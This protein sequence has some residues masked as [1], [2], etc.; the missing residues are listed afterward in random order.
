MRTIK[1]MRNR[2]ICELIDDLGKL[3]EAQ[4]TIYKMVARC[5]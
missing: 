3:N 1:Q 2:T 5:K 4:T